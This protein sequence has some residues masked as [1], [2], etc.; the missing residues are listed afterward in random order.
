MPCWKMGVI[1]RLAWQF[2]W[3]SSWLVQQRYTLMNNTVQLAK[4]MSVAVIRVAG[5]AR[6][7]W[8]NAWRKEHPGCAEKYYGSPSITPFE[9]LCQWYWSPRQT[10]QSV[11]GSPSKLKCSFMD[12]TWSIWS[13]DQ[14]SLWYNFSAGWFVVIC[15]VS[16]HWWL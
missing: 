10:E 12:L 15:P 13:W 11:R 8:A 7:L 6:T 14:V 9:G 5:R 4:A 3:T 16:R 1:N 2:F